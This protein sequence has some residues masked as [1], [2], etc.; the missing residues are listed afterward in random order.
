MTRMA[1]G[2]N[3]SASTFQRVIELV[4]QCLQWETCLV[5]IDD[6]VVYASDLEQHMQRLE[7]VLT[8]IKEAGLKLKPDKCNL[9]QEEV[10]FLG[11]IVSSKGVR[12]ES[13]NIAKIVEWPRPTTPKQVKQ[14]VATGSY[15]RRFVKNFAKIARPLTNLTKVDRAFHWTT[16]CEEAFNALKQALIGPDL[17]GYPLNEA[18]SFYLD[19]DASE[20]G[21]GAVLSQM[22]EG[23][24]RVIAFAS[25]ATNKAE[26]NY[27]I[28]EQE[29]LAVVYF[30]QYFRQY[31]LG[32]HFVVRTD[33]QALVWLF[34]L[35]EPSSKIA[36]WID[37]LSRYDFTIE[38]RAGK[39]MGHC[40]ALSRCTNPKDCNCPDVDMME[41]L[42]CGPCK[43]CLRRSETMALDRKV[44]DQTEDQKCAVHDKVKDEE[45][46]T[47]IE[48]VRAVSNGNRNTPGTSRDQMV[49]E[50]RQPWAAIFSTAEMSQKQQEDAQIRPILEAKLAGVKP[51]QDDM[52][53]KCP[54]TRQYWII[55]DTLEIHSGT[56]YRRFQKT[57]NGD[58]RLQLVVPRALRKDVVKQ[59]HDPVTAGHM[60]IKRTKHRILESYFWF[61]LK[62]DVTLY[63][64]HCDICEADKKPSRKPKAPLGH[65]R[66]GAPLDVLALDFTGPFPITERKYSHCGK[67]DRKGRLVA[68]IL[69]DHEPEK[70]VPF[71]CT[72][73][74]F[75][76]ET[77]DDLL[78][79]L[80]KYAGHVRAVGS[81]QNIDL[82]QILIKS[83]VPWF[84]SAN[85]MTPIREEDDDM[86]MDPEEPALPPWLLDVRPLKRKADFS[87]STMS[88]P[89]SPQYTDQR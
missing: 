24:E 39:R 9:L 5:Y 83:N 49:P 51:K 78:K 75:R 64:H 26:R 3:N 25:R 44:S 53:D 54:E 33:H 76:C 60:G 72:L 80:T 19:T 57:C 2:L 50:S 69:R 41:P 38:Y 20:I 52:L 88:L 40:D 22:Q 55:C 85:D 17:I 36:R 11:H 84:V 6:I 28:T 47:K 21:L 86:F 32:R 29:L 77:R 56:L 31:L 30:I 62:S 8:R 46:C 82:K 18:G 89:L 16:E 73:C 27:C 42:K 68:H 4:L 66:V 87:P 15:Y 71:F 65:I 81:N 67:V 70:Q 59:A 10:V 63:V 34:S 58:D 23:R 13:S 48:P 37:I 35:K 74:K 7:E 1:F 45:D 61:A 43:K 12:P 79:H 14:F